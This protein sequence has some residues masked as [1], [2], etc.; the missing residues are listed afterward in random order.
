MLFLALLASF[1]IDNSFAKNSH[2]GL[3]AMVKALN[4]SNCVHTK[5]NY[6]I[7]PDNIK[8]MR[9]QA[10][11]LA[12]HLCNDNIMLEQAMKSTEVTHRVA[13]A[14]A[15]GM[16]GKPD[17]VLMEMLEDPEVLVSQATREAL[18][19]IAKKNYNKV[20][21][22][23]PYPHSDISQKTDSHAMWRLFFQNAKKQIKSTDDKNIK[24]EI[25]ESG[26]EV[27]QTIITPTKRLVVETEDNSIPGFKIK[28]IETKDVPDSSH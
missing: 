3:E 1:Q 24:P 10:T 15:G 11:A 13:A 27:R 7:Y 23:G 22:F 20:I 9:F 17:E 16:T 8:T 2:D 25:R 14:F 18:I 21:D 19:H 26:S 28:R 5:A 12:K 6:L 4:C